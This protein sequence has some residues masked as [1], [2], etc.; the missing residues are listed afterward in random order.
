MY[1]LTDDLARRR[2]L[3]R[4]P[5]PGMPA[6]MLLDLPQPSRG[7]G[8]LLGR[9]YAAVLEDED[10]VG[11]YEAYLSAPRPR[12]IRPELF[13]QRPSRLVTDQI[14]II[15]YDPPGRDWPWVSL[16]RWP[17]NSRTRTGP[18]DDLARQCYTF[19]A[20]GRAEELE[21]H[22]LSVVDTLCRTASVKVRL[23]AADTITPETRA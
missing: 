6:V 7:A 23:I 4:L 14:L 20:F 5:I 15:R 16:C 22:N 17:G 13:D 3:Y 19:E 10:E 11:E 8:L 2:R 18:Q 9:F 1:R 21:Q 12:P